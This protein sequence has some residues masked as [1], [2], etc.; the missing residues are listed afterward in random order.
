MFHTRLLP[1]V[2]VKGGVPQHFHDAARDIAQ[3]MGG[4]NGPL[5][6]KESEKEAV[7]A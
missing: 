1:L 3:R 2:L 4:V 5:L 7:A 6:V